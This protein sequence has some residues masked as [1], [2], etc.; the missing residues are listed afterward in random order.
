[1]HHLRELDLKTA[2]EQIDKLN[3]RLEI[4]NLYV[5]DKPEFNLQTI[6]NYK[7]KFHPEMKR[8][9]KEYQKYLKKANEVKEEITKEEKRIKEINLIP[10][11]YYIER[12]KSLDE[13]QR[14]RQIEQDEYEQKRKTQEEQAISE[15]PDYEHRHHMSDVREIHRFISDNREEMDDFIYKD[16]IDGKKVGHIE[17]IQAFAR[18]QN[19]EIEY[20]DW[21]YKEWDY[22]IEVEFG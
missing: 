13:V 3:R 22:M 15:Y 9:L 2:N 14:L 12:Q 20:D 17:L 5:V 18:T 11:E 10:E 4:C 21:Q 8:V 1:M 6:H 16:I 19:I 7:K